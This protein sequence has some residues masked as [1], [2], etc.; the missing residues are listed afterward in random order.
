MKISD[1]I[2]EKFNWND[3]AN[4]AQNHLIHICS[5]SKNKETLLFNL[6]GFYGGLVKVLKE[7]YE[8]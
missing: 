6:A 3:L 5:T 1:P 4:T 8:K 7:K 2:M